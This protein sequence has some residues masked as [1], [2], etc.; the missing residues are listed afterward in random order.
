MGKKAITENTRAGALDFP[1][2]AVVGA[3]VGADV[4]F[5]PPPPPHA[6]AA[7]HT[8]VVLPPAFFVARARPALNKRHDKVS[9]L[10]L[11]S[12]G[13]PVLLPVT[14]ALIAEVHAEVVA[15]TVVPQA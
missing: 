10:P 13:E 11:I 14:S 12:V 7:L 9:P 15:Y 4:A 8:A 5:E 2:P 6:F 1:L 3:A